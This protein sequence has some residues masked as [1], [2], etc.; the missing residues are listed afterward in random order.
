[1]EKNHEEANQRPERV[2]VSLKT[3]QF[4]QTSLTSNTTGRTTMECVKAIG[5]PGELKHLKEGF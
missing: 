5:E 3:Q 2:V 4:P 1:M